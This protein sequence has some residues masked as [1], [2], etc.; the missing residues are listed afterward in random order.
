M[1]SAQIEADQVRE[2]R[3]ALFNEGTVPTR[4]RRQKSNHKSGSTSNTAAEAAS[5]QTSLSRTQNL[6]K[7]ELNRVS[8]VATAI[9]EDGKLLQD[10]KD[11]HQS[12]NVKKAKKALTSL[13]RAQQQEYRIL[14]AS[15]IFFWT[16]VFY[17]LFVRVVMH[18]PFVDEILQSLRFS[19]LEIINYK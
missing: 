17:I 14:L 6:L 1:T 2:D 12:L 11:T 15:I 3:Q 13:Q 16:V 9:E 8:Q 5:I 18:I 7:N 4:R 19:I 10:T